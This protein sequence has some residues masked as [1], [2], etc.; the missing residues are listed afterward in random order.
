MT[1]NMKR[2]EPHCPA[3][4]CTGGYVN[5]LKELIAKPD[6]L[7]TEILEAKKETEEIY[8]C[9]YCGLVW[10][11]ESTKQKG[12]DAR[13]VGFYDDFISPGKFRPISEH[14][15]IRKENTSYYYLVRKRR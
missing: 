12:F 14:Y 4:D 3:P 6:W 9:N 8:R 11:Q 10:F 13:P 7:P 5:R 1:S 2:Y 15:R